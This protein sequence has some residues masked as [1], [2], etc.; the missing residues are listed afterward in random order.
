MR[1]QSR[2][3]RSADRFNICDIHV[4]VGVGVYSEDLQEACN[5][6]LIQGVGEQHGEVDVQVALVKGLGVDGHALILDALPAVGL[7]DMACGAGDLQH[8]PVQVGDV[9]FGTCQCL[10]KGDLLQQTSRHERAV[11]CLPCRGWGAM[12]HAK[13]KQWRQH[14]THSQSNGTG[15]EQLL[16]LLGLRHDGTY[17]KAT[18]AYSS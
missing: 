11:S 6:C 18:A 8:P 13:A 15:P 3:R 14:Q 5:L 16:C 2:C 9:E 17:I 10:C 7:D 4:A 1:V 12:M